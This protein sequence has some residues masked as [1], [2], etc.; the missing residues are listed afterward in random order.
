MVNHNF[1]CK[2]LLRFEDLCFVLFFKTFSK[3][4]INVT[5]PKNKTAHIAKLQNNN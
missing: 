1:S 4:F 5:Q 2:K 3:Y